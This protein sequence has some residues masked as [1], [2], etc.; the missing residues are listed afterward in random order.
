MKNILFL[1]A[2]L[3]YFQNSNCQ[4]DKIDA[5]TSPRTSINNLS[6]IAT[7]VEYIP[8]ETTP[9]S[10]M[11]RI[12]NVKI[13]NNYIYI[14]TVDNKIF[15]FDASGRYL[16]NLNKIGRGP[17]EYLYCSE[18]D[19]NESNSILAVKGTKE[20]ILYNQ[21]STG[22][23]FL[24]RIKLNESPQILNFVGQNDNILLQYSNPYGTNP[25]SKELIN[26]KGETLLSWPNFMKFQIQEKIMVL[27]RYENTSFN[28]KND[29]YLKEVGNDTIFRFNGNILDPVLI[30][31]T[32]NKRV[33][34]EVRAN[35]KYYA[36]HMYEYYILQKFFGS[37]R[38]IYYTAA[39]N[40]DYNIAGIYDKVKKTS[41]AV[42]GKEFFKD[43]ISGGVNFE[44]QY[45][46][47]GTFYSW[48]D[49]ITFKN[50]SSGE[51]FNKTK[52]RNSTKHESLK[53]LAQKITENDNPILIAVKIR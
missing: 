35:A 32:K 31:D 15:C 41:Y 13:R 2:L 38:F 48:I 51:I 5:L 50:Y 46:N 4:P 7:D 47:N 40:K 22:F 39:F 16:F 19:V 28:F 8:L 52:V 27:S 1:M 9:N 33:S 30:F 3:F 36:D 10:I 42:P 6:E 14:A 20:I 49:A 29:L 24:R 34:P 37:E 21:V 44:P 17:E 25:I 18:F 45:C 53:N 23:N 26:L 12:I 11:G 43:D